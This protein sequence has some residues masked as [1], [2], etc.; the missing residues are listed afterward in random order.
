MFLPTKASS[1]DWKRDR[2][3]SSDSR[4]DP[5][6]SSRRWATT[7]WT[8]SITATYKLLSSLSLSAFVSQQE[9]A[10]LELSLQSSSICEREVRFLNKRLHKYNRR[11]FTYHFSIKYHNFALLIKHHI[12]QSKD[13]LFLCNEI[14]EFEWKQFVRRI[15]KH[16][17][18]DSICD[19]N[20]EML[21]KA[22]ITN[23]MI[24]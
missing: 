23:L 24:I 11:L 4:I 22:L 19:E 15:T 13:K 21:M 12:R 1:V 5:N 3:I 9:T 2:A 18:S 10:I 7:R 8:G 14:S 16:F 6:S 17:Q 20:L